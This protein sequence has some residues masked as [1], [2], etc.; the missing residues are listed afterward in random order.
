MAWV[1]SSVPERDR[2]HGDRDVDYL[3]R[4]DVARHGNQTHFFV[5]GVA[6]NTL[7]KPW[8]LM[9]GVRNNMYLEWFLPLAR[10]L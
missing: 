2:E 10:G 5:I 9:D 3:Q 7:L 1:A 6:L 4:V 8:D